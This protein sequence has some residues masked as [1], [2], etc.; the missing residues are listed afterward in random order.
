MG[1]EEHRQAEV[2][3][4][5]GEQ[6]DDR[7]LDEHVERRGDLVAHEHVGLADERPGDGDPLPLASRELVGVAVGVGRGQRDALEHL[8]DLVSASAAETLAMASGRAT[9]SPTG[10]RGFSELYGFWK[11]YWI[12]S[13]LLER[14]VP[15]RAG[16]RLP[17]RA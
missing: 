5:P 3:L 4:Q 8:A 6:L 12:L 7:R 14:T 9:D 17:R 13:R 15:R 16:E 1:D 10:R 2:A 11:T